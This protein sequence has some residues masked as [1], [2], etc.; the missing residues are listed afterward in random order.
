MKPTDRN[1]AER[2]EKYRLTEEEKY[3]RKYGEGN[4][5]ARV[6]EVP[7]T[8]QE[9]IKPL[10]VA[11]YKKYIN[12]VQMIG[13]TDSFPEVDGKVI[14]EMLITTTC[15]GFEVQFKV[16][17]GLVS[18]GPDNQHTVHGITTERVDIAHKLN[19]SGHG[20]HCYID[21]G[22]TMERGVITMAMKHGLMVC[23]K[24]CTWPMA[25]ALVQNVYPAYIRAF[26]EEQE[27]N[28]VQD[29]N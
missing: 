16:R 29:G 4:R 6:P 19:N 26:N 11:N 20:S 14:D 1:L 15:H 7:I 24:I 2:K 22:A 18:F 10:L 17:Y 3:H 27:A 8:D 9:I 25:K 21:E 13:F 23:K 28:A 5:P 12:E